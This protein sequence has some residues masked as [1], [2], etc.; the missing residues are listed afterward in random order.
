[1]KAMLGMAF[2][3]LGGKDG[4][5]VARRSK[6]GAVLVPY[7]IPHNPNT[8]GQKVIRGDF[9]KA[10]R[11]FRGLSI[12]QVQSWKDYANSL[13]FRDPVT[14]KQYSPEAITAFVQLAVKFLQIN[15]TGTIPVAPPTTAFVGDNITVTANGATGKVTFVAS[16]ANSANVKTEVLLQR[17]KGSHYTPQQSEYRS[18]GFTS[19]TVGQMVDVPVSSGWY[20]AAYRFVN[21]T[22]GQATELIPINVTQVSLSISQPEPAAR[23][24]A[25]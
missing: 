16:G 7:V 2:E 5:T 14:G 9:A 3:A 4:N 10:T 13:T 15:P 24:K 21:T 18:K 17:L 19:M 11:T 22:T 23:K 20:A 6:L 8:P 25:A 12:A 1:M